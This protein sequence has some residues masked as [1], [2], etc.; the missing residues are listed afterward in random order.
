M[1]A[2]HGLPEDLVAAHAH[3]ELQGGVQRDRAVDLLELSVLG[4]DRLGTGSLRMRLKGAVQALPVLAD[5]AGDGRG[6]GSED[7]RFLELVAALLAEERGRGF[8]VAHSHRV[9]GGVVDKA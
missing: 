3:L 1:I 8:G 5:A 4:F 2:L 6:L 7:E 9:S